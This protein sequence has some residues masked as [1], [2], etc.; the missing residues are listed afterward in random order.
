VTTTTTP[1]ATTT[2]S[3]PST[4]VGPSLFNGT[5]DAGTY[6]PW[7]P[8]AS[9]YGYADNSQVH[10]G[11]FNLSQTAGEGAYGGQFTVPGW[12]GGR[13]RSQVIANRTVNAGGDD[14]YS[15]MF[16]VPSGW[17]PGTSQFWGVSIAELNF[18]GLGTGGP[19]IALQAHADHVTVAMQTGTAT[20]TAPYYAYRSN[21]DS[22]GTP[23][24]PALYAIPAPM[25]TGVWH[26]LV[27]H[28]HWATNSQGVVEVWHRLKGQTAW[29]KTVSLSGYPTL[30]TNPDGSI[31]SATLD[32]LQAYRGPSTAPT[33]VWLDGFQRWGSLTS[34]F[35][36]LP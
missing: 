9:N 15:L 25:Q 31:P 3:V 1:S 36:S 12:S 18:Q 22:S 16:Y 30:Q 19:S 4:S 13:T 7:T 6:K 21:A 5:F 14:Y 23:N 17:S 8:Q 2:A 35:A 20:T 27:I 11:T 28:V 33:T 24:M 34:A 29:A 26:D 10:F 32:V